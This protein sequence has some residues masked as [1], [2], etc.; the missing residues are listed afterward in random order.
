MAITEKTTINLTLGKI[1]ALIST[2]VLIGYTIGGFQSSLT[3]TAAASELHEQQIKANTKDI[4]D[5]KI[6]LS[7]I[8][9]LLEKQNKP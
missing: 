9:T 8:T 7:R 2:I 4:T 6:L 3:K 1:I 5:M